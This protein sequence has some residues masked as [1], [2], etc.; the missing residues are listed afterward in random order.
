MSA[1][2]TSGLKV[3]QVDVLPPSA[4]GT[5]VY[6]LT[7]ENHHFQAGPEGLVVHNTDSIFVKFP[8]KTLEQAI[9][10]GQESADL[11]T[12]R[13]PH[14]AFV[15]GYEKTFYPFILFCR[16]RYVGMKYEED[17]TKCKRASMGVVLKRRDNAPI[18]KDVFGGALDI[19][20]LDKDVKKAAEF[21][22]TML[23]KVVKG[24]M[25]IDKFAIT[26]QLRD[27]YKAMKEGYEGSATIPAH[28]I[29]ADRMAER[30]P[31]NKPNVGDRLK[32][33]YIQAPDKRLQCDKIEH[34]AYA[35]E[36]K[37]PLDTLFYV[38]NQIQNPVAQLFALCIEDIPGYRHPS[39]G[40]KKQTYEQL[41]E[42]YMETLEDHEQATLKVLAQKEKQLD[43]MLFLGA[44]YIQNTVRK[45]RTGPLYAFFKPKK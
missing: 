7:T 15:I 31:G 14:K 33:V 34:I 30:D 9:K 12:K 17:P 44:E 4:P 18:V 39:V 13:C 11:I 23:L 37:L 2:R 35:A 24:D 10:L 42:E 29:L 41:Y 21:V 1:Y 27:D 40:K 32:F 45:S 6:D 3:F 28:R 43:S 19:L 38:T 36:K 26:K 22:K 20:L 16:K 8:G 25:P 5:M